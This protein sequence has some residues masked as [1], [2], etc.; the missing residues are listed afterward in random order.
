MWTVVLALCLNLFIASVTTDWNWYHFL[1]LK[2]LEKYIGPG[3]LEM[4][5]CCKHDLLHVLSEGYLEDIVK[6]VNDD[7]SFIPDRLRGGDI[8]LNLNYNIEDLELAT[9]NIWKDCIGS[10]MMT[11][12]KN[13]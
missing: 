12:E 4:I 2:S 3:H 5:N 1:R 6:V 11:E 10:Y 13:L 7:T 8:T 9:T